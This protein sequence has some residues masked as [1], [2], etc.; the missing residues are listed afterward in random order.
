MNLLSVNT[1]IAQLEDTDCTDFT[2]KREGKKVDFSSYY[3]GKVTR[4]RE[5]T[6]D[7]VEVCCVLYYCIFEYM[8]RFPNIYLLLFVS[9]QYCTVYS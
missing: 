6:T 9:V 8:I 7:Q 4:I 5:G 3:F 2:F 1:T